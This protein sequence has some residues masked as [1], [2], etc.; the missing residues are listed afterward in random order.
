MS[1]FANLK[2]PKLVYSTESK[3][4][5]T[6]EIYE[7][8]QTKKLSIDG[9]VQSINWESPSARRTVWGR[10]V[11]VLKEEMPAVRSILILGLGGGTMAHLISKEFPNT[12][13]VS[14]EID[15]EIIDVG[16]R[17]FQIDEI[18]NHKI[19]NEDALRVIAAPEEFDIALHTFDVVVVDILCG[20]KYPDLGK[21]GTFL[22]GITNILAPGGLVI[23]NR[24]YLDHFQDEV[25]F[26]IESLE[27]HFQRVKSVIIAGKTNS[28]NV[29]ILGRN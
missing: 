13:M 17:F 23:F 12:S 26:F 14:V 15:P 22:D 11:D 10:L 2:L 4:N 5:G 21:S 9:V 7:V 16:K 24:I 1:V 8:G 20:Q 29:L 25:N 19:I 27:N 3:Y 28:D 6:I 18:P